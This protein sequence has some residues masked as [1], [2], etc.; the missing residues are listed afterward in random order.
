MKKVI[1]TALLIALPV[2]FSV[3]A[4]AEESGKA[5]GS[6]V[7]TES[8]TSKECKSDE[9]D[10][11]D[12][13]MRSYFMHGMMMKSMMSKQIVATTDGGVV[14]LAGNKIM[15]FDKNLN[16][17]KEAEIKID[18]EGIKKT[19]MEGKGHY[20]MHKGKTESKEKTANEPSN[21]S[22]AQGNSDISSQQ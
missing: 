17:V 9:S 16:L 15:K 20:H 5:A 10:K 2:M 8:T 19:M 4:F 1:V 14:V 13:G 18:M 21:T 3:A 12:K 6:T 11:G 7:Q 22:E